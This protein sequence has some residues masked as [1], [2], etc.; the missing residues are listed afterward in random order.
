MDPDLPMWGEWF[1]RQYAIN[2]DID[3]Q[4]KDATVG[5]DAAYSAAI[6]AAIVEHCAERTRQFLAPRP[7]ERTAPTVD[8]AVRSLLAELIDEDDCSF[9]HHGGCQAHG[10]L[11][12][13]PGELCPVEEAKRI[14]AA[15]EDDG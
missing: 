11:S 8:P 3:R 15:N 5:R 7:R 6:Y 10:Y 13:E 14:I 9:D 1:D 12:L 2:H 4:V